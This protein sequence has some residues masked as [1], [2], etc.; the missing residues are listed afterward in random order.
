MG[1]SEYQFLMLFGVGALGG[2]ANAIAGG[3]S[4]M[5]MP[6]LL[7]VGLPLP[8]ALAT[9]KLATSGQTFFT[10]IAFARKG[11]FDLGVMK[12]AV[13]PCLVGAV[14]GASLVLELPP[15]VLKVVVGAVL[16]LALYLVLR[17]P[18]AQ[19]EKVVAAEPNMIL[20]SALSRFSAMT[21]LGA[22][23]GFFGG[24]VGLVLVPVLSRFYGLNF[25]TANAVK[26]GLASVMNLVALTI[27]LAD[28]WGIV[29][30]PATP[31]PLVR[32]NS[33]LLLLG[34]M[35]CGSW[36]G[37]RLAVERGET[38]IRRGLVVATVVS[39]FLVV[40]R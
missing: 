13:L 6:C 35:L 26:A 28:D 22:Y 33:G 21:S 7:A 9:N 4:L 40:Y 36:A 39:L 17:G 24:G 18:T 5:T 37:V 16:L 2:I 32:W 3:A 15:V 31:E 30:G 14:V 11:Y 20:D 25:L 19:G 12:G 38:L 27:F 8:A 10:A 34:G 29:G 23:G 1:L